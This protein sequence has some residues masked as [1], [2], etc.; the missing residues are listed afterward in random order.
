MLINEKKRYVVEMYLLIST[1]YGILGIN[2]YFLAFS[3]LGLDYAT[4]YDLKHLNHP[5]KNNMHTIVALK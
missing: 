5:N 1:I 3:C 2:K 4:V